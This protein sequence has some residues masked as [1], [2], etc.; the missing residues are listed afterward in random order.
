M[1]LDVE[2]PNEKMYT[3][4]YGTD[5]KARIE[6]DRIFMTIPNN[7]VFPKEVGEYDIDIRWV[8]LQRVTKEYTQVNK[9]GWTVTATPAADWY[10]WISAFKAEHPYYGKVYSDDLNLDIHADTKEGMEHFLEHHP[11]D[12]FD[13][14]DI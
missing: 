3:L 6:D 13:G 4:T 9:S 12:E 10:V 8:G 1:T 14:N 11:L 7:C 5:Y 2:E